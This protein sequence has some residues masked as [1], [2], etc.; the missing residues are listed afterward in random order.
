MNKTAVE[1]LIEQ[2]LTQVQDYEDG[3]VE[4]ESEPFKTEYVN[5]YIGMV[6][7]S[8]FVIK[9][10]EMEKDQIKQIREM[11]M[12]GAFENMSCASAIVEFDKITKSE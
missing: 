6:D 5:K 3:D 8:E 9:A 11:L 4:T 1:W 2:I 12:Q 7:L 10:L